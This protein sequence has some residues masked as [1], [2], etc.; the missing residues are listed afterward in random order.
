VPTSILTTKLYIPPPR[1]DLVP[2][3]QLNAC[4]NEGITRKLTL[5]CAPAGFGKTTMLS[6]WA[7]TLETP[8]AW[9]SL[10]KGDND[11]ARFLTYIVAALQT[12]DA[13][14]C[15]SVLA[16]TQAPQLPPIETVLTEL[17][18]E[19]SGINYEFVLILDDF[20]MVENQAINDA[21]TFL[22]DHLPPKMHL[23]ISG[24]SDPFLPLSR[25]RVDGQLIELRAT[26]LRFSSE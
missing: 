21:L 18:N 20:H 11:L 15:E 7:D 25:L 22:I 3:P 16:M 12:V 23:I 10:D 5:I 26:N 4:L 1:S 19:V 24:R 13:G 8:L 9:L 14:I 2:R 17:I 6:E